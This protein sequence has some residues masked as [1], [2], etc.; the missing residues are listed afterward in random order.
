[1]CGICGC[2]ITEK[3]QSDV[4]KSK[5]ILQHAHHETETNIMVHIEQ[6]LLEKNQHYADHNKKYFKEKNILTLNMLSSPGSG[7]TTLL[8]KTISEL[9][10]KISMAV[11]E[12]DQHTD[13]DANQIRITQT[14]VVQ[15]NTGKMCHL[16][17][18]AIGHALDELQPS[19]NSLLLI[20]NV[21]NLI[22]PALFDLGE[23]HKVV[24]LSVTE[25]DNKPLKYPHMFH[26]AEVL[27]INKMDLLPYVNFDVEKCI[28]YAKRINPNIKIIKTSAVTAAGLND[29][30]EWLLN[31]QTTKCNNYA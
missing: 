17:A 8:V 29:W 25:G 9:K 13:L 18:H 23:D 10:N 26:A 20:E 7:K 11:I 22:C 1:M 3:K 30:Y 24:V 21:G 4:E 19:E 28:E 27:L 5:I 12:G 31:K 6:D 2:E 14:P 15:I 16:D